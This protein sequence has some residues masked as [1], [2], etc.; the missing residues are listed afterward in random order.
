MSTRRKLEWLFIALSAG[1]LVL[2]KW[3]HYGVTHY[4]IF[5]LILLAWTMVL[6]LVFRAMTKMEYSPRERGDAPEEG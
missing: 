4:N 2:L 6:I 5:L 1:L 3:L